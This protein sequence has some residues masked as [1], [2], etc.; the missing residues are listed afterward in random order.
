[1]KRDSTSA[2]VA[3][4]PTTNTVKGA[5]V[6][7]NNADTVASVSFIDPHVNNTNKV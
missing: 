6:D 5:W 4:T 1:V 2:V 3:P 7:S